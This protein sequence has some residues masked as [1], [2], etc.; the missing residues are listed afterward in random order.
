[1]R[2]TALV[3]FGMIIGFLPM[4]E[5]LPAQPATPS[6]PTSPTVRVRGARRAPEP[7]RQPAS[8]AFE[9]IYAIEGGT[10]E[11]SVKRL[12]G[13]V[14]HLTS[15]DGWEGVGIFNGAI[16]RGVF[17]DRGAPAAPDSAIGEHIIDWT[18][19]EGPSVRT[20]YSGLRADQ[21]ARRW[22]RLPDGKPPAGKPRG[23]V[24]APPSAEE[25]PKLGEYVY[26]EELP[27]AVTKVAPIYPEGLK[28]DVEGTVLVQA[29][30]LEDGSVGD[31]VVVSSIGPALDQAAI[32]SIR[33]W[34][35][36]PAMA[37]GAPVAVWVAVPVRFTVR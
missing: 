25:R 15:S 27:E 12:F 28:G 3:F 23:I 7:S 35:F 22:R 4:A 32:A 13:D 16:Y 8:P 14:Y 11:V 30:V 24:V 19:P 2:S 26:V 34:R 5:P 18:A 9:G 37:K 31:V 29:L 20:T 17:R 1:M 21:P 33:Q 36:K 10:V 6:N